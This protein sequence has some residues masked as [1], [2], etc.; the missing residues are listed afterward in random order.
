MYNN[1]MKPLF[2]S[3]LLFYASASLSQKIEMSVIADVEEPVST[4]NVVVDYAENIFVNQ[5]DIDIEVTT[6]DTDHNLPEHTHAVF[7]MDS[8]FEYRNSNSEHYYSDVTLLLT[9]RDLA[10]GT[11][12]LA[13]YANIGSICSA[14]SLVI[15]EFV[16]NGLDGETLAHELAHVLGAVHDGESPCEDTPTRG[17]LMSSAVHTGN[18]TFSQC[19]IDT[20]H[21]T[22]AVY[23][24]CLYETNEPPV[25]PPIVNPPK[26]GGGGSID[27]LFI[28]ILTLTA[29]QSLV[30]ARGCNPRD[31]G[32][33]P[34]AVS[35]GDYNV[36][37]KYGK[38][39]L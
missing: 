27:L 30:H 24:G 19:S 23:G 17:Y 10:L 25:Q 29:W 12:D 31:A 33:N 34:A 36:A 11:R 3:A 6:I 13:G 39:R 28:L 9:D 37:Q 35:N 18:S 15:V 14:N 8:L 32:S 1:R 5:L 20:I 38:D 2:F 7:L 26:R 4:T 22:I 21:A 16:N